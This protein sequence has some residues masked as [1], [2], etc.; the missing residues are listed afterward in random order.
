MSG[1]QGASFMFTCP[2]T[3]QP[4]E[5]AAF[6]IG[7]Y[8]VENF[9][10]PPLS[11]TVPK[12]TPGSAV[13]AVAKEQ[14]HLAAA[15]ATDPDHPLMRRGSLVNV[16]ADTTYFLPTVCAVARDR[17]GGVVGVAT[18]SYVAGPID[19]NSSANIEFHFASLDNLWRIELVAR[20][21]AAKV[22]EAHPDGSRIADL[23]AFHVSLPLGWAYSPAQGIDSYVGTL[24]SE[25]NFFLNFDY[26]MYSGSLEYIPGTSDR[27]VDDPD[28]VVLTETIDGLEAIIIH[29]RGE[30]SGR[31]G[32]YF[33]NVGPGVLPRQPNRFLIAGENFVGDQIDQALAIFRSLDFQ[34]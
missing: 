27:Y 2:Y 16:S 23:G 31:V 21:F 33:S 34:D 28:Y 30:L 24:R 1:Q 18:G 11:A 17:D 15:L 19:P 7:A 5:K 13:Y 26:G 22:V 8:G 10:S 4:G 14:S 6:E 32:V 3:I 25:N 20:A 29:P 12:I 9:R